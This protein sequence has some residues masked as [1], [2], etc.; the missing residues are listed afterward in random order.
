M[1][2]DVSAKSFNTE[3]VHEFKLRRFLSCGVTK[4]EINVEQCKKYLTEEYKLSFDDSD[5]NSDNDSDT[6]YEHGITKQ[7]L[8]INATTAEKIAHY[9]QLL[10]DLHKQYAEELMKF[11][12]PTK[13]TKVTKDEGYE[14]Y[15]DKV[16]EKEADKKLKTYDTQSKNLEK[17]EIPKINFAT[18]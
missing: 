12:K 14:K 7:D 17:K 11:D 8:R 2:F 9:T 15:F 3:V 16:Y 13:V 5:E 4:F 6:D 10:R 18:F 1:K